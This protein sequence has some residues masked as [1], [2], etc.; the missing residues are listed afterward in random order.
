MGGPPAIAPHYER[1][2]I[3]LIAP[4]VLLAA[5]ALLSAW[6]TW[7]RA[8]PIALTAMGWLTLA[9]FYVN[10]FEFIEQTGGQSHRAF[11]TGPVEPK[12]LALKTILAERD[13]GSETWIVTQESWN[14]R[15]LKYLAMRRPNL[16]VED[17]NGVLEDPGFNQALEQNRVWFV[18]FADG[19]PLREVRRFLARRGRQLVERPITGYAGRPVLAVVGTVGEP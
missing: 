4:A 17:W 1:Y 15:P 18:E 7:P 8:T 11:R 3:C 12:L 16:R 13:A 6:E 10:Y 19:E 14:Y 9:G 5:R 2:A